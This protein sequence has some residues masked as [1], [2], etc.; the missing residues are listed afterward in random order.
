MNPNRSITPFL[1]WICLLAAGLV[2]L[3]AYASRPG[4]AATPAGRLPSK[5]IEAIDAVEPSTHE[6]TWTLVLAVHP[7]CPCTPATLDELEH[8]LPKLAEP[9]RL[10]ALVRTP[11]DDP[12]A[13]LDTPLVAKLERLNAV[14]VTDPNAELAAMIGATTS[15]H[16]ALFDAKAESR[17][18]GG[19]TPTRG[20]TGPNTGVASI[21]SIVNRTA[22]VATESVV[23]GCPLGGACAAMSES[24]TTAPNG[25]TK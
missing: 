2:A 1:V 5:V 25:E 4:E 7:K 23:Y 20:H 6:A 18:N 9:I 19:L 17:F 21:Q 10:V 3:A 14:I 13:W 22:L 11:A 24:R 8:L 15:G 16:A 12:S